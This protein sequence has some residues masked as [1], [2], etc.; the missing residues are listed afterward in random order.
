MASQLKQECRGNKQNGQ[1]VLDA[2]RPPDQSGKSSEPR[3]R[4]RCITS[5]LFV[6]QAPSQLEQDCHR[7]HDEGGVDQMKGQ[8]AVEVQQVGESEESLPRERPVEQCVARRKK[9]RRTQAP[10]PTNEV[11][12]I[13]QEGETKTGEDQKNGDDARASVVP[14]TLRSVHL[15][16]LHGCSRAGTLTSGN[17]DSTS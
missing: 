13:V 8:R 9:V 5:P 7:H 15:F 3:V 6:E 4:K 1:E 14:D 11:E 12:I 10:G 17:L 2:A 16:A